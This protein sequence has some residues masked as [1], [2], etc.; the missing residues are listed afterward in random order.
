MECEQV[1][2]ELIHLADGTAGAALRRALKEHLAQ[3]A[4]CRAELALLRAGHDA[5][6]ST[7]GRL[8]PEARY[9]TRSRLKRLHR[10]LAAQQEGYRRRVLRPLLACASI[11][12]IVVSAFFLYH[13]MVAFRDRRQQE[14]G[15]GPGRNV[16]R[17][18]RWRA[19][20]VGLASVPQE[21][22]LRVVVARMSMEPQGVSVAPL[23]KAPTGLVL[24]NTPGVR[25]PVDHV[26]YDAEQTGFWW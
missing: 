2:E 16:T 22:P 12:A 9:L 21:Q 3:C 15:A 23:P 13:D 14:P 19:Q 26:F 24:T 7:A 20:R 5:L 18:R 17:V 11:A 1:A 25:V 10:A 4:D 8:A 6:R